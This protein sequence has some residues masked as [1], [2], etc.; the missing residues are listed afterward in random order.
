M[1][2]RSVLAGLGTTA[3]GLG[4]LG[5]S[6]AFTSASIRRG[7]SID[8]VADENGLLGITAGLDS[9]TITGTG[10]G[11]LVIDTSTD[12]GAGGV[13]TNS[14]YWFG[15]L[16][17]EFEEPPEQEFGAQGEEYP[18][19]PD[20]EGCAEYL[21]PGIIAGPEGGEIPVV[22]D[23]EFAFK[24][25]NNDSD[26]HDVSI[27]F[28]PTGDSADSLMFW[29][30]SHRPPE[31]DP[32]T[33]SMAFGDFDV[34]LSGYGL[35]EMHFPS[36]ESGNSVYVAFAICAGDVGDELG[37]KLTIDTDTS[38]GQGPPAAE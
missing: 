20:L 32:Q 18:G 17:A 23:Q 8:V 27:A 21:L 16:E 38:N 29:I 24:V 30:G 7:A 11:E 34:G 35:D 36:V 1:K 6:G 2:R 13:N 10:D 14:G 22:S 31:Q 12:Q 5:G 15:E 9:D 3:L 28:E 37:G 25:T 26:E 4:A 33:D 19:G